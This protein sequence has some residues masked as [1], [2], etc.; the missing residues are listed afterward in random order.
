MFPQIHLSKPNSYVI[1]IKK[2]GTHISNK[3]IFNEKKNSLILIQFIYLIY[4]LFLAH[5]E[6]Y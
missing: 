4:L 6:F 1:I 3:I 5:K 2:Q